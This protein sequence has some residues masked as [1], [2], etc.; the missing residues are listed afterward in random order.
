MKQLKSASIKRFVMR[1]KGSIIVLL[2]SAILWSWLF[3]IDVANLAHTLVIG[4]ILM[5]VVYFVMTGITV[6]FVVKVMP[7]FARI[8]KKPSYKSILSVILIWAAAEMALAWVLSAVWMGRNGSWDNIV[9]FVSL[10][11]LVVLTPLRFLT[12]LFGFF[13]TSAVIGTGVLLIIASWKNKGWRKYALIFWVIVLCLNTTLWAIY[14][15]PSGPTIHAVITSEYLGEPQ[16]VDASDSD[17]VV[18]P[19]YGLDRYTSSN[20]AERFKPSSKEV[21]FTGTKQYGETQGNSN[22]L[23]YGSSLKGFVYEH[24]KSRLIVGGEYLPF[25]V[26]IIIRTVSPNV[27]YDFQVRRAITRGKEAMKPFVLPSGVSIGNAACSS[28]INPD[29]YRKLT[30]DGATVLANSASLEIFRGSRVF[31]LHHD[32][33]AKFMAV[34]N[35]RPFLQSA[36]NWKA[37]ALDHNGNKLGQV[38][39]VAQSNV[40]IQTN[41]KKTPYMYIG[42]WVAYAGIVFAAVK[43]IKSLLKTKRTKRK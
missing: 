16:K 11:P 20:V 7:H 21:Y 25:F 29:D 32:G 24:T 12:R 36:H 17:I 18:L 15:N 14:K 27:Y 39:P 3:L 42:E 8:L 2:V 37:F 6:L 41:N 10:T 9:P 19:E 38:N 1:N 13:G 40:S 5:I 22:V 43:C 31:A 30:A 26:E 33:L 34:S 23:I 4:Y 28:I 35:A